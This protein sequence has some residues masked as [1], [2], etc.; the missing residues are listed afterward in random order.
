MSPNSL[1]FLLDIPFMRSI[2]MPVVRVA[3]YD[4]F[5]LLSLLELQ[6]SFFDFSPAHP[7]SN[8]WSETTKHILGGSF[9]LLKVLLLI[10]Y[11]LSL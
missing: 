1:E 8:I 11:R 3:F 10:D 2:I 5:Y 4:H 7:L 6:H 9:V